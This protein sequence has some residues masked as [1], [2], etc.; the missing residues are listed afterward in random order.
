MLVFS[1]ADPLAQEGR[2]HLEERP[3][4]VGGPVKIVKEEVH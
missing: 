1:V 2:P 4:Q 3:T